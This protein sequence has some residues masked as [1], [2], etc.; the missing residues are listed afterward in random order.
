MSEHLDSTDMSNSNEHP[1]RSTYTVEEVARILG[2]SRTTAYEC[3]RRGDIQA[4]R[5]GVRTCRCTDDRRRPAAALDRS[6]Q[7]R[8]RD[9]GARSQDALLRTIS[10]NATHDV[11][12]RT[13]RLLDEV[14]VHVERRCRVAVSEA[15]GHGA[16]VDTGT[17]QM[18][19]EMTEVMQANVGHT[20]LLTKALERPRHRVGE[21]RLTPIGGVAEDEG[22]GGRLDAWQI[23]ARS[24]IRFR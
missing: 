13:V 11:G 16:H 24:I 10:Q 21:P 17:Q 23:S 2:I 4:R 6:P 19:D 12:R 5:F 3:V 22:V 18:G 7:A 14:R 15:P 20:L 1:H 9:A 8:R